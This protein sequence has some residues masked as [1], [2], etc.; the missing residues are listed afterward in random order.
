MSPGQ[1]RRGLAVA[2]VVAVA[3]PLAAG[4]GGGS[5]GGGGGGPTTPGPAVTYSPAAGG[6]AGSLELRAAAPPTTERIV[7]ELRAN[8]VEDL[9][10]IAFELFYPGDV[11]SLEEI[12]EGDFLTGG[13]GAQTT[14][15]VAEEPP[16]SVL[17]GVTR[18][19]P[20]PG[21]TGSGT[22]LS[23]EFSIDGAGSGSFRFQDNQAFDAE[24][25][26]RPDISW[27]GGT[28][29]VVL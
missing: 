20:V 25:S 24:G 13:A 15:Q 6:G 26:P 29:Q 12:R 1:L 9:Y 8:Q 22:L 11:V 7:L 10:G 21:V 27:S 17:V 19:G 2:L 18:L 3:V 4:C 5:G 16:E 23:L 28:I 14:L